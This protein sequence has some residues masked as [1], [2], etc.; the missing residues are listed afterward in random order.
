MRYFSLTQRICIIF[1]QHYNLAVG[2]GRSVLIWSIMFEICIIETKIFVFSR[3]L[4][5]SRANFIIYLFETNYEEGGL[6]SVPQRSGLKIV[7]AVEVRF[8]LFTTVGFINST[9]RNVNC[10]NSVTV[11]WGAS[12]T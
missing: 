3:Q 10:T 5:I 12:S 11:S 2:F 4:N 8:K 9:F 7:G 1:V 6:S